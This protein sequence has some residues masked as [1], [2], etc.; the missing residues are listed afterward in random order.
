MKYAINGPKDDSVRFPVSG[1][2]AI[3]TKSPTQAGWRLFS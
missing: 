3:A 1:H 2:P